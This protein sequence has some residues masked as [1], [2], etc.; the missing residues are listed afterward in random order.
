MVSGFNVGPQV[1]GSSSLTARPRGL[2]FGVRLNLVVCRLSGGGSYTLKLAFSPSSS[3]SPTA[4]TVAPAVAAAAV[5]VGVNPL[6]PIGS[7]VPSIG[8]PA[9]PANSLSNG[10]MEVNSDGERNGASPDQ[11]ACQSPWACREMSA[12][13]LQAEWDAWI[14]TV[15]MISVPA[16]ILITD[17][18]QYWSSSGMVPLVP[19]FDCADDG[20]MLATE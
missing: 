7:P 15:G 18:S 10:V 17:N 13:V 9:S 3:I 14:D 19:N 8:M 4:P 12:P 20:R 11:L 5:A 1:L 6:G 16:L 2:R